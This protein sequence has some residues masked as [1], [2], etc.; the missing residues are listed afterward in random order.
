MKRSV[1]RSG[2]QLRQALL[3]RRARSALEWMP[4]FACFYIL[5]FDAILKFRLQDPSISP[6]N[7]N[8]AVQEGSS[9]NKLFWA[10]IA[11]SSIIF[12]AHIKNVR[13]RSS[14]TLYIASFYLILSCVSYIWS[15][16]PEIT[17]RRAGLQICFFACMLTPFLADLDPRRIIFGVSLPFGLASVISIIAV[18]LTIGEPL[19]VRGIYAQ[20]NMLGQFA[21]IATFIF[22]WCAVECRGQ[23]RACYLILL[24][25][26]T[27]LLLLSRSKTSL[28]LMIAGFLPLMLSYLLSRCTSSTKWTI[29]TLIVSTLL[30]SVVVL[31]AAR[32]N[33]GDLSLLLFGDPTFTGRDRIWEFARSYIAERPLLGHGYGAFWG[34][35]DRSS[36]FQTDVTFIA[37]LLQAHNGYID[38]ELELGAAGIAAVWF[39]MIAS[40][41]RAVK[42]LSVDWTRGALALTLLLFGYANNVMESSL[43]R[44]TN[45]IWF[46]LLFAY[47]I[48]VRPSRFSFLSIADNHTEKIDRSL[49][50]RSVS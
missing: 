39:M 32:F 1:A 2:N 23:K 50:Q 5:I 16:H 41:I 33:L 17:I 26:S 44:S 31:F 3:D 27:T 35:G 21:A 40:V 22:T 11:T 20:K 8:I 12:C 13:W 7:I 42:I 6:V 48:S 19:G 9:L 25:I 46:S 47:G 34:V 36:A 28:A 24:I 14:P 38:V 30:F 37:D 29:F 45:V 43:F 15:G 4:A 18:P 10:I 49:L